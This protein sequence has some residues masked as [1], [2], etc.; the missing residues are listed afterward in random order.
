M[1]D[2]T[3][4]QEVFVSD[5]FSS[6]ARGYDFLNRTLSMGMD[7]YWRKAL[8]RSVARVQNGP[9]LDLAA[10]TFDVSMLLA[11]TC[12]ERTILAGDLCFDMLK[13]GLP[14]L[15]RL[16]EK[17]SRLGRVVPITANAFN[18]PLPDSCLAAVTVSFGLR[19]MLPRVEALKE[20][21]RVLAPGGRLSVLEF[22]SAKVRVWGGLYNFYLTRMLPSIG[23]LVSGRKDAYEYLARSIQDF[24]LPGELAS[25]MGEAGFRK[26]R[27][28]RLTGGIVYLHSAD[29]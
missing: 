26:V 23:G 25:E 12:P 18:L 6:I 10:G 11:R 8:V 17:H 15:E 2:I 1:K 28:R 22:G 9:L 16:K 4:G 13:Q 27:Y 24:P 14:K 5:I 20:I 7:I 29:K 3:L 21:N 19:N